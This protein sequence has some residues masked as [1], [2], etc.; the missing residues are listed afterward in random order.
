MISD[1]D[2][3]DRAK[4]WF[5][6]L[7]FGSCSLV[8][9]AQLTFAPSK[10][11]LTERGLLIQAMFRKSFVPWEHVHKFGVHE[12]TQ[13]HGP[14]RQKH[15]QVGMLFHDAHRQNAGGLRSLARA[16]SGFDGALPDNYGYKHQELAD[17]LNSYLE[18]SRNAII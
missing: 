9:M 14:F 5:V 11:V 4:G 17:L 3:T 8:V 15:R 2:P 1:G 18:A 16:W 6:L 7:L 12:W 10:V 13:W